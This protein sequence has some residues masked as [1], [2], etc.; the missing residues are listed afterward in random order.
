MSPGLGTIEPARAEA[1]AWN[2]L[3]R[4]DGA[5]ARRVLAQAA[6]PVDP[7]ALGAASVACGE[8]LVEL[9]Q[10]YRTRPSGP[11]SLVPATVADDAGSADELAASLLS[12]GAGAEAVGSLQTHLHY[13]GRH[14]SAARVGARL[15]ATRPVGAA[16]VAFDVAC[17]W[18]RAGEPQAAIEWLHRA[19]D[20]GF[21]A[22]GVLDGDPDLDAARAHPDWELLRARLGPAA[23]G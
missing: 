17:A 14:A 11:T 8:G 19:V 23:S 12:D 1:A 5:G 22:T 2:L 10:A 18:S 21:G 16:Q 13:A 9:V 7:F 3:R 20:D 4:G 6:G 15:H